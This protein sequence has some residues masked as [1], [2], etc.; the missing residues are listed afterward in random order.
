MFTHH[1]MTALRA[2]SIGNRNEWWRTVPYALPVAFMCA[3]LSLFQTVNYDEYSTTLK[4]DT[5]PA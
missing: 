4:S 1:N 5:T 3:G 2:P